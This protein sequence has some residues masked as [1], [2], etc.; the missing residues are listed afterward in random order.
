MTRENAHDDSAVG[1]VVTPRSD[2]EH[3]QHETPSD[4][5]HGI[6]ELLEDD[7]GG[8]EEGANAEQDR[9]DVMHYHV[10]D[11]CEGDGG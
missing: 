7:G 9:L 4:Y 11:G 5:D 6:P 8:G 3:A 10:D 1:D 2:P